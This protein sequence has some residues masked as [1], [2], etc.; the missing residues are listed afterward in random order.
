MHNNW[1]HLYADGLADVDDLVE[2]IEK[3]DGALYDLFRSVTFVGG[4][5]K[6][7]PMGTSTA[8]FAYRTDWFKEAG[9]AKFP[10]TWDEFRKVGT[11]RVLCEIHPRNMRMKVIVR[12]P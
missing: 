6:A 12:A 2:E 7:V 8:T 10:E 9:A 5:F 4:R 1:S 3:R 11:W